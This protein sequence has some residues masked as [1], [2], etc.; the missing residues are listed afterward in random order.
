[1]TSD[2]SFTI[3]YNIASDGKGGLVENV[4]DISRVDMFVAD[5][6]PLQWSLGVIKADGYYP[7]GPEGAVR[8]PGKGSVPVRWGVWTRYWVQVKQNRPGTDFTAWNTAV[9]EPLFGRGAV[10]GQRAVT[11]TVAGTTATCTSKIPH[12]YVDGANASTLTISGITGMSGVRKVASVP[13]TECTGTRL[14]GVEHTGP[15]SFTVDGVTGSGGSGVATQHFNE[16]TVWMADENRDPVKVLDRVPT[17][18]GPAA[19]NRFI[20]EH[21]S[22]IVE[23]DKLPNNDM[24]GYARNVFV[25]RN[26]TADGTLLR[27][28]V[29]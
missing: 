25:L 18:Y 1:V 24:I 6:G 17:A 8:E 4:L 28:P 7:T 12:G 27:R 5:M 29:R 13:A 15:C 16:L 22:S 11:C 19:F 10:A 2:T 9:I 26:V 14:D 20:H 3:P 23:S 21:D